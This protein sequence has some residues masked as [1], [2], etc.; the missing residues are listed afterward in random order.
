MLA[1]A[2]FA[3]PPDGSHGPTVSE[4]EIFLAEDK[5]KIELIGPGARRADGRYFGFSDIGAPEGYVFQLQPT[6]LKASE[7]PMLQLADIAAYMCSHMFGTSE[8]D[9]FLQEQLAR[10]RYWSRAR[11]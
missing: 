3:V 2:C 9:L 10:I 6:I 8:T 7:V 11:F 5:T 1:Q 4:C